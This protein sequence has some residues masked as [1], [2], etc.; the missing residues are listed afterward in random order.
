M[1]VDNV[2]NGMEKWCFFFNS[3]LLARIHFLVDFFRIIF[4]Y[5]LE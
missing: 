3:I 4:I 2:A 1:L 5:L